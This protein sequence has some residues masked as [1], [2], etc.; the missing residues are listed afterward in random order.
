MKKLLLLSVISITITFGLFSQ[1][2]KIGIINPQEIIEKSQR[3][4]EIQHELESMREEKSAQLRSLS[5]QIEQKEKVLLGSPNMNPTERQ[6]REMELQDLR[7]QLQRRTED[8]QSEFSILSS[9]RL[10]A[11][12]KEV[13][14]LINQFGKEMGYTLILDITNYGAVY[15]DQSIDITTEIIRLLDEQTR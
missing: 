2:V 8:Y 12:E 11:F 3:G 15:F 9:A 14:P 5:E 1:E 7:A 6:E 4:M 10:L 13:G